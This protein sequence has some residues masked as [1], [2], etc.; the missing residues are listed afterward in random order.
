MSRVKGSI[1]YIWL[2]CKK[3]YPI[4]VVYL[5][6]YIHRHYPGVRQRIIDLSIIPRKDRQKVLR[7][8]LSS[9]K[10]DIIAFSWRDIQV[11]APHEGDPSLIHAFEFYYS[12]NPFKKIR[13]AIKGLMMVAGY[14]NTI[15]ENLSYIGLAN[16]LSPSSQIILGGG[17]FSVFAEQIIKELLEGITGIIG[18]GEG[19]LLKI[20][21]GKELKGERIAYCDVVDIYDLKLNVDYISSIFTEYN[22]Y[23]EDVVGVQT[24]RGCPHLCVFCVY[25]YIEG[26]Q[27]RYRKPELVAKEIADLHRWGA[28][29][30]WLTDA[31]FIPERQSIP[32][33]TEVLERL[34]TQ[35]LDIS[36][37]SYIRADMINPPLAG[38]MV[39]SGL[40]D[41]EVSIT[42]GSQKIIDGLKMGLSLDGLYEGC[43]YLKEAGYKGRIILNYSLNSPCETA[44]TLKDSIHSYKKI[45]GI[46]GKEQV[47]PVMFFLA[48][49]PHTGLEKELIEK[50]YLSPSYNPLALNPFSIKKLLYNPPPLDKIIAHSYLSAWE[51]GGEGLGK[52]VFA[53]LEKYNWSLKPLP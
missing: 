15:R 33:C 17:A 22:S 8:A 10:P 25:N 45:A 38:L 19:A 50:G 39:R 48:V 12:S 36:W 23:Q 41:L 2:P 26:R 6:N 20:L 21:E 11:F 5:A 7:E 4:G 3:I 42:S 1:L 16:R 44:M 37:S 9:F 49:Q 27:V 53:I 13:S 30:F 29:K 32:H 35:K 52:E 40:C 34:I 46:F 28:R 51:K 43:R 31:Q 47:Y 14:H 24:K 18:E